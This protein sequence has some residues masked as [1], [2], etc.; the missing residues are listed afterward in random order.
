MSRQFSS[1]VVAILV[2]IAAGMIDTILGPIYQFL[3]VRFNM[4]L[5]EVGIF[6]A[7]QFIGA[8]VGCIVCERWVALYWLHPVSVR[9]IGLQIRSSSSE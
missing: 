8:V 4:N 2:F 9:N 5:A 7:F 6:T 1:L 3:A